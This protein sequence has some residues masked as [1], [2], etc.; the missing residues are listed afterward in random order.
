MVACFI[1]LI[2]CGV[3]VFINRWIIICGIEKCILI[4]TDFD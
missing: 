1:N 2:A 3:N 4:W